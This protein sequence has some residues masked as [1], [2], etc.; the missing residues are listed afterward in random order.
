M[1]LDGIGR[2]EKALAN[3]R[4]GESVRRELQHLALSLGH[5]SGARLAADRRTGVARNH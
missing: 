2:D 5:L 1:R 4:H 3:L